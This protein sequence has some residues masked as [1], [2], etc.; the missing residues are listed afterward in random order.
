MLR[1]SVE[2]T[3]NHVG[4][5]SLNEYA[6]LGLFATAQ[7][8]ALTEGKPH[9][10]SALVDVNGQPLYPAYYVTHV[11][12]P[13]A[14]LLS[15]F[16]LW[17]TVAVGVDVQSF[18]GIVLDSSYILGR[19]GEIADQVDGWDTAH[20]PAMRAGSMFVIDTPAAQHSGEV[21]VSAPRGDMIAAL[22]RLK[23]PP[24]AIQRFQQVREQGLGDE[25]EQPALATSQPIRY[26]VAAGRDAA[27]G[28][29]MLFATFSTVMDTA[30]QTLLA[31]NIW[32]PFPMALL[33]CL[34]LL[35]R[36]TYYFANCQAGQ[37]VQV[38]I[39][40]HMAP[41]A[42]DLHGSAE[43]VLSAGMLHLV[44]ELYRDDTGDLLVMS[45]A[46][47]LLAVPTRQQRLLHDVRRLLACFGKAE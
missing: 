6:L 32:P 11:Q 20:L 10:L 45:R 34:A 4:L 22:P 41:C 19:P 39:R 27:A 44:F 28:H 9:A 1:E 33:N 37:T 24:A 12:I 47:K 38:Q 26:P 23:T 3:L 42:P 14:C 30:E 40:G 25:T 5:G 43:D 13:P 21:Q 17:S 36:E 18:G 7:A 31:R 8:H 15:A 29:N 2:L 46:T 16:P 35:E